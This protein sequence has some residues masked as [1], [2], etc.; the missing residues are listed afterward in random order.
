MIS[1]CQPASGEKSKHQP[2][3]HESFSQAWH[4]SPLKTNKSTKVFAN[5]LQSDPRYNRELL[6]KTL[7]AYQPTDRWL[8]SITF[9]SSRSL[10][11]KTTEHFKQQ[12]RE[13]QFVLWIVCWN[14]FREL[15][16]LTLAGLKT[17]LETTKIVKLVV[18]LSNS[19]PHFLR[20]TFWRDLRLKIN[21]IITVSKSKILVS[22]LTMF[23][24]RA[25]NSLV[26]TANFWKA[27]PISSS[28]SSLWRVV[29][30]SLSKALENSISRLTWFIPDC[31]MSLTDFFSRVKDS[32][33]WFSA[34][35]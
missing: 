25:D 19:I 6:A 29:S 28:S 11:I 26:T 32:L 31:W 2:K 21:F 30:P 5:V 1:T 8:V 13:R 33:S 27:A 16:C 3:N 34:W 15:W 23:F 20:Q 18:N 12:E 35:K 24:M 14:M 10:M 17:I 4:D 9:A 22:S 7:Q